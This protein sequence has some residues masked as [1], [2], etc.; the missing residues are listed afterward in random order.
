LSDIKVNKIIWDAVQESDKQHIALHLRLFGVLKPDQ[1]IVADAKTA[2]P[3]ICYPLD[4]ITTAND[5]DIKALG[6]DWLC[7]DI[8]DLA[9]T[10]TGCSLY[11]Q[12][13]STCL[14]TI[15]ASREVHKMNTENS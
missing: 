9:K 3:A 13:L 10:E 4:E 7:R 6:I 5:E 12:S 14:E 8:C 11:G 1:N 2:Q 15:A